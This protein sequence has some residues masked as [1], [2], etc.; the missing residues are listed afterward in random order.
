MKIAGIDPGRKKT[1]M[2]LLEIRDADVMCLGAAEARTLEEVLEYLDSW[3]PDVIVIEA[4]RLYPWKSQA[5]IWDSM[6][7]SQI[8]GAIKAWVA[9]KEGVL[10]LEQPASMRKIAQRHTREIEKAPMFRG[11]P[12]AKDALR[13]AMWYVISRYPKK[14]F[15]VRWA[16]C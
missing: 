1:G 5:L 15:V 4:F 2:A 9:K 16:G 3:R 6:L 13:H 12:H 14:S 7:P 10:V 11:K 8:I